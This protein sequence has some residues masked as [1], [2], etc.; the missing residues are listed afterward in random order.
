MMFHVKRYARVWHRSASAAHV[1]GMAV[2]TAGT[3]RCATSAERV[4]LATPRGL[5]R[6]GN[7]GVQR[8]A[9][10]GFITSMRAA[11]TAIPNSPEPSRSIMTPSPSAVRARWIRGRWE[12]KAAQHDRATP[13]ALAMCPTGTA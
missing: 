13:L 10:D 3:A 5:A 8:R 12:A 6:C 2:V 1:T 9:H 11:M 7:T 4:R